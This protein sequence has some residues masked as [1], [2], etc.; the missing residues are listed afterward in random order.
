MPREP[1]ARQ[2]QMSLVEGASPLHWRLQVPSTVETFGSENS[3]V[4]AAR[5]P[6]SALLRHSQIPF[7]LGGVLIRVLVPFQA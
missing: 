2:L 7:P 4:E 5:V 3:M 6:M 1:T